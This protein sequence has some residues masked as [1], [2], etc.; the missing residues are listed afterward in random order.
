MTFFLKGDFFF[1]HQH[2]IDFEAPFFPFGLEI[3]PLSLFPVRYELV[4]FS[5]PLLKEE[6]DIRAPVSEKCA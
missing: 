5:S 3:P 4:D 1:R 2:G 6:A